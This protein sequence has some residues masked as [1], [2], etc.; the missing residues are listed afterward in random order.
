[1]TCLGKSTGSEAAHP[2]AEHFV[3][4]LL[5]VGAASDPGSAVSAIGRVVM[6]NS[7]RSVQMD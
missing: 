3:P 6:G 4:L 2:T 5:T 1:M 7:M